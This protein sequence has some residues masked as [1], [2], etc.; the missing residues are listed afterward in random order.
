MISHIFASF[1]ILVALY[2][3]KFQEENWIDGQGIDIN[4]KTYFFELYITS[5]YFVIITLTS[6]GYGDISPVSLE[7][8]SFGISLTLFSCGKKKN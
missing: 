3:I 1:W 4:N 6:V 5:F 8:K 2:E 7:E